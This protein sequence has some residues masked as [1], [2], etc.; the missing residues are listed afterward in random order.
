MHQN[1]GPRSIL[2][3]NDLQRAAAKQRRHV[4]GVRAIRLR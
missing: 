2:I 1:F 4:F 3:V